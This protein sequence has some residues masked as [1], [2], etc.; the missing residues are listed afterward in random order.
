MKKYIFLTRGDETKIIP[1][2]ILSRV[3]LKDLKKKGFKKHHLE[4]EA[5]NEQE[6]IEK[7]HKD[8]ED[9]LNALGEFSGNILY[10]VALLFLLVALF[11][12]TS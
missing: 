1:K 9:N 12:F 3:A 2:E 4:V 5:E 8:N 11:Y 10:A 6:A 7:L